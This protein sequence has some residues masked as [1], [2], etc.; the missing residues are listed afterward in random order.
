MNIKQLQEKARKEFEKDVMSYKEFREMTM[1]C[2]YQDELREAFDRVFLFVDTLIE[3]TYKEAQKQER[4][5]I[6]KEINKKFLK[7]A[8]QIPY[9][10]PITQRKDIIKKI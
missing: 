9:P 5:R 2:F 10:D 7:W 4:Q 1:G 8:T 6:I 3:Q